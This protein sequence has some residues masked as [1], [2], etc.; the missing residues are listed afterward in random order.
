MRCNLS[1]TLK[2]GPHASALQSVCGRREAG[3]GSSARAVKGEITRAILVMGHDARL[4]LTASAGHPR[5]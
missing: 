3:L 2:A 1:A 5:P 4:P